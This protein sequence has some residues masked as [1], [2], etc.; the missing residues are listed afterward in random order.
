MDKYYIY[1]KGRPESITTNIYD[2]N[3]TIRAPSQ[4]TL[5]TIQYIK[6]LTVVTRPHQKTGLDQKLSETWLNS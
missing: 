6:Y 5:N 3:I 4:L 2:E 1:K